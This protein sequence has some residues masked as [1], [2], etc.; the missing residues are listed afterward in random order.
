MTGAFALIES[1]RYAFG[2]FGICQPLI[3][4]TLTGWIMGDWATGLLLGAAFQLL[5]ITFIPVGA[6]MYTNE[7]VVTAA[8]AAF[9]ASV[10]EVRPEVLMIL[11]LLCI[12]VTV[13]AMKMDYLARSANGVFA[14]YAKQGILSAH[15]SM[16]Q[17]FH[18]VGI[19]LNWLNGILIGWTVLI[20]LSL[21]HDMAGH[22][23]L[24]HGLES[25]LALQWKLLPLIGILFLAHDSFRDYRSYIYFLA[26]CLIGGGIIALGLMA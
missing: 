4:C 12:P 11:F 3:A 24:K 23:L 13:V 15:Y 20:G 5:W 1:D 16:A 10:G 22:L 8:I 2:Q 9:A 18:L 25:G 14:N 6:S 21:I 17:R 19:P 26:G 7:S